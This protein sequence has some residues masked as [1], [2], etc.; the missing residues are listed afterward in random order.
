[1]PARRALRQAE[2]RLRDVR[3]ARNAVATPS[4]ARRWRIG[5]RRRSSH[6]LESCTLCGRLQVIQ[7]KRGRWAR[8]RGRRTRLL[9]RGRRRRQSPARF[10]GVD[11]LRKLEGTSPQ[12]PCALERAG[13]HAPRRPA[14]SCAV[15]ATEPLVSPGVSWCRRDVFLYFSL[16]GVALTPRVFA[17]RSGQART[18]VTVL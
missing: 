4:Y 8:R 11:P 12:R 17:A 9:R 1:M 3:L 15:C 6:D 13:R 16:P 14:C 18:Q 7:W 2:E 5:L 10:M